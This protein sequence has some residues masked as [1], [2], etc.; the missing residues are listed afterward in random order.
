[1]VS[2]I[3]GP[4][5]I[6]SLL[7]WFIK[8]IKFS[9]TSPANKLVVQMK[10]Y[11]VNISILLFVAFAIKPIALIWLMTLEKTYLNTSFIFSTYEIPLVSPYPCEYIIIIR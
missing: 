1:M 10:V 5:F 6:Q 11:W 8:I 2:T 3:I 7:A 4:F 9:L